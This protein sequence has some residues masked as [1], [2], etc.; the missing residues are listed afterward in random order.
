MD[1][2]NQL[3]FVG[4]LL[5]V[6]SV[7]AGMVSSRLGAPLLLIFLVLGMLA[8]EDGILGI[9]F[10]DYRST[11]AVGSVALAIILFEG[12]LRTPRSVVRLVLWPAVSLATIG[13]LL[14]ALAI[15]GFAHLLLG[16][17]PLEGVL[18]GSVLASTDAAAVFMLL[19]GRGSSVNARISGTLE[20][21]SGMNDPMAVFLTLLCVQLLQNPDIHAGWYAF[22]ELLRGMVGGILIGLIGGFALRMMV[23]RL[24]LTAALYPILIAAAALL[25]FAGANIIGASGFLAVYLSGMV[26]A[27]AP[28]RAQQVIARF[29][30][31][32][33]WLSQIAMFLLLGLLVTPS[34]LLADLPYA[35]LIALALILV[36]RPGSVAIALLPFR[37]SWPERGF[38]AWVGLRGAVPIFLASI[39]V[40]AG[41]PGAQHYF[42]VAFVV[43]LI[44]L[45]IQGWT[46]GPAARFL[47]L[48]VPD[49]AEAGDP[50]EL[51]LGPGAE[52][53][54]AGFRVKT[55]A[56]ALHH[57]YGALA[58]PS[59][60]QFLAAIRDEAPIERFQEATPAIGDYVI[61]ILP[62]I[63]I[64]AVQRLFSEHRDAEP[65]PEGFGEFVL[66]GEGAADQLAVVY[67]L[68]LG[69]HRQGETLSDF[70]HERLG[71]IAV[72][73]DRVRIGEIELVVRAVKDG[74]V[75]LVGLELEDQRAKLPAR[76]AARRFRR[77][78]IVWSRRL[79]RTLGRRLSVKPRR[80]D[81]SGG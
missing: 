9:H 36:A 43:V 72:V 35:I 76:R 38:I 71:R 67:G 50:L 13:V 45:L 25:I 68:D 28:Y 59:G 54:L 77:R 60:A 5:I 52:R 64:A 42:N 49:D 53:E 7:L 30:D 56:R 34:K 37:F 6:L 16:L 11:F 48:T 24:N 32:L 80:G 40:L 21:E 3:I 78:M 15:A 69:Q 41:L 12:G 14:S 70:M 27:R 62:P 29:L 39:P 20:L 73:A 81:R 55:G 22:E 57:S 4:A 58:L 2:I 63:E 47:G 46:I 79:T 10:S 26:L 74:R 33:A 61:A 44:S 23:E 19:H 17:S 51:G 65:A 75:T 31:G 1:L 18:L 66:A 8:G